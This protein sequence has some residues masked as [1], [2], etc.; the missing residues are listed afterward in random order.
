MYVALNSDINY[1]CTVYSKCKNSYALILR[2]RGPL[3]MINIV[4]QSGYRVEIGVG[5][6]TEK[7]GKFIK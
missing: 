4:L 6:K 3:T 5:C 2:N 7:N 1:M